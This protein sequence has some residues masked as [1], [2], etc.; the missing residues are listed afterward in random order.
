MNGEYGS[1]RE[2]ISVEDLRR[3]E[4]VPVHAVIVDLLLPFGGKAVPYSGA[5]R[6][7]HWRA[8]NLAG[9]PL[10]LRNPEGGPPTVEFSHIV[11][12]SNY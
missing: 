6:V 5:F 3:E 11:K 10:L 2:R 1:V 8:C 9:Y 7:A 4:S 12:V